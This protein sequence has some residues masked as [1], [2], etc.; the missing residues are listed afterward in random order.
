MYVVDC[1][2]MLKKIV[3][4]IIHFE[5]EEFYSKDILHELLFSYSFFLDEEDSN[6]HICTLEHANGDYELSTA[7]QWE[8]QKPL[9]KQK[10]ILQ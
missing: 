10:S 5:F 1:W 7:R 2:G 9:S 4:I 6:F 3:N 8:Q